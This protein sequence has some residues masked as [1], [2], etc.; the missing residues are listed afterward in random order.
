[1]DLTRAMEEAHTD[2]VAFGRERIVGWGSA[3]RNPT[4]QDFVRLSDL[5][6]R[7]EALQDQWFAAVRHPEQLTE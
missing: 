1:M 5:R 3:A 7:L 4:T 6:E 2:F